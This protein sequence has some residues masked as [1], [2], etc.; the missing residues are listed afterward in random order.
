[1][2]VCIMTVQYYAYHMSDVGSATV[3]GKD[4]WHLHPNMSKQ[5]YISLNFSKTLRCA[6]Q[7]PHFAEEIK[8]YKSQVTCPSLCHQR[9]AELGLKPC[10]LFI[11]KRTKKYSHGSCHLI[12]YN[13]T[14]E[15]C[16]L[17]VKGQTIIQKHIENVL[18]GKND[19]FQKEQYKQ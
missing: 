5:F 13:N 9:I 8:T 18:G 11:D 3:R 6:Y 16:H 1:M 10:D 14:V 15:I 19:Y 12:T 7:Q 4:N 17:Q 2:L